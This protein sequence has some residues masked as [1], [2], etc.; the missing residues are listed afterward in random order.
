MASTEETYEGLT[1]GA[2]LETAAAVIRDAG[3]EEPEADAK[4]LVADALGVA[5]PALDTELDR[6]VSEQTA[7]EIDARVQRRAEREPLEYIL[8]RAPF[9]K[10]EVLVDRRVLIPC[11]ET[12][13][14]VEAALELPEGA[15]VHEVGT[16]SGAV[17]LSVL[18]ERPDLRVTA[19]DLSADAAEVALA[20]A[21]NLGLQLDVAI[22]RGLPTDLGGQP[23][24][25]LANLPYLTERSLLQRPLEMIRYEPKIA[26][27]QG[28]GDDG[29]GVI[30]ELIAETPSGWRMAL[31][32]DTHHG[33]TMRALLRDANTRIDYM[34]GERVTVGLAP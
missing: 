2:V 20:N 27:M 34:G 8:G 15:W 5:A 28:S 16:G 7:R 19:S 13:L 14:L 9:R 24:I 22:C 3:C 31:E 10:I 29:L 30:R 21:A 23:D 25:V 26:V 6:E 32:H 12:G 1:A 33:A 11:A 18:T 4:A 17:A